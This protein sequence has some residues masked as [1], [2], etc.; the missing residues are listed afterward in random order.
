MKKKRGIIIFFLLISGW[1]NG[2][3]QL[4]KIVDYQNKQTIPE[5]LVY[6][7]KDTIYLHTNKQGEVDLSIFHMKDTLFFM[8]P[9]YMHV[10][11]TKQQIVQNKYRVELF[12]AMSIL[13]PVAFTYL[14]HLHSN[15]DIPREIQIFDASQI[16]SR[17][18]SDISELMMEAPGLAVQR[19][20]GA[21]G[22]PVIHGLEANRILMVMDGVRLNNALYPIGHLYQSLTVSPF[23]L[24]RVEIVAGPS[25]IYG[26]DALGGVVHFLTQT[27][28]VNS[29]RRFKGSLMGRYGTATEEYTF[30]L[31]WT[32]SD[33]R[34]AS[35]TSVTYSDFGD[36]RMGN[37]RMHG[38]ND[39]GIIH[40]Y[41]DN[42]ATYYNDHPVTNTDLLKQPNTAYKQYDFFNK[43][44]VQMAKH[45]RL[46]FD[47]QFHT[48]SDIPRFDKLNERKEGHLKYAEWRYGPM[49]RFMFSP[50]WEWEAHRPWANK[51][52]LI[53]AYQNIQE[54]RVKRRFGSLTRNFQKENLHVFSVNIDAE[55][56]LPRQYHLNYGAEWRYNGLK[57][58][59]FAR[60]LV[61]NGH[62]I[63]GY[64][65]RY[66]VPSRYPDDKAYV[67]DMALYAG[68]SRRFDKRHFME[69][70]LRLT[71]TV[72]TARWRQAPLRELAY[73]QLTLAN[74]AITPMISY[75]YSPSPW[76]FTAYLGSGFRSPN[77][78]DIGISLENNGRLL[79]PNKAL[80][81]EYAYYGEG[82]II[83]KIPQKGIMLKFLAYYNW[84]YHY[85]DLR[86]YHID[87]HSQILY[88]GEWVDLYAHV[89]N[90]T[91]HI[92]GWDFIGEWRLTSQLKWH[93]DMSWIKGRKYNG[94][95]LP[96]IPPFKIHSYLELN[97]DYFDFIL[98]G[99]YFA[100][101]PLN[102][103]DKVNGFDY[104]EQSPLDPLT[105]HYVGFPSWFVI[106][107][108]FK[109]YLSPKVSMAL[110][111]ENALDIHYK[112]FASAVSEPGR[113][114]K[115]QLTGKF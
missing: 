6:R 45:S 2:Y 10:T 60:D 37:F 99:I 14:R 44:V 110:G 83:R 48:T 26:S 35:L 25:A 62:T 108:Y 64:E 77:M 23:I 96:S 42:T 8:H 22:S 103:Y 94:E 104:L 47:T 111:L 67:L 91:A 27:P 20:Q 33:H 70:G 69:A 82:G 115:I 88:E 86:P 87:G 13:H 84:L 68:V 9:D 76:R 97:N 58:Y 53:T 57:S 72:L 49:Q 43:T 105:G 71:Q 80:K 30:H 102:E 51:L 56:S 36:I 78:T 61:V 66:D 95:P 41:S 65:G 89:N 28:V 79:V 50:R 32:L 93:A 75:I 16:E 31:D 46:I 112:R 90:G 17:T 85:I 15:I 100:K 1:I 18:V 113:N 55:T 4:I 12:S 92:Y 114:F 109:L 11:L 40:Q 74:F 106:N 52:H 73:R 5:V 107:M 59:A 21:G 3:A 54:S 101:K 81:P 24:D 19:I 29:A 34:W 39:W 63:A 98:A 38:Y 7:P